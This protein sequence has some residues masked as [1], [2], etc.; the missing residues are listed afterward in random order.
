MTAE[1]L[2][3]IADHVRTGLMILA[4]LAFT[5]ILAWTILRPSASIEA[6]AHL[7]KDNEE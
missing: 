2:Q 1:T 3:S 7:W 4:L 5:A 6:E